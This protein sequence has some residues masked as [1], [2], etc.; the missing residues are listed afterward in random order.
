[1][2]PDPGGARGFTVFLVD[3]CQ[4]PPARKPEVSNCQWPRQLHSISLLSGSFGPE[5]AVSTERSIFP[6]RSDL[7]QMVSSHVHHIQKVPDQMNLERHHVIGE[8]H[9]PD[10]L[11]ILD[12]ILAGERGSTLRPADPSYRRRHCRIAG[13]RLPAQACVRARP[14]VRSV[15]SLSKLDH[16]LRYQKASSIRRS[17]GRTSIRPKRRRPYRQRQHRTA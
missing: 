13:P 5:Q 12:D 4:N 2:V 11:A 8:I 14:A 7:A 17:L 3:G 9:R 16:C 15:S 10:C 6:Y 1:V